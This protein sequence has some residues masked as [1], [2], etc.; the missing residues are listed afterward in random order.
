[1]ALPK[2]VKNF[3]FFVDGEGY[4]GRVAELTLPK[5][6]RKVEEFRAGG[7]SGPVDVDMGQEKLEAEA[8]F[9][10]HAETV[11]KQYGAP[12]VDAIGMRFLGYA[13][14]DTAGASHNAIEI[15]MRG[16]V[17][18]LDFGSN[19]PGDDTAFKASFSL[20]YFKYTLNGADL[21]EI[22]VINMIE[23]VNGVDRLQEQRDA[24]GV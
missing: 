17:K 20:S 13:E 18:E 21:V 1:M 24:L 6:A 22:D 12:G 3:N 7:M 23:K 16:R 15:V 10:E 9:A 11:L 14:S 5:L 4:A 8:T 19:K 2:K